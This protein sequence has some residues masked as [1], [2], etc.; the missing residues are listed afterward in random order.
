MKNVDKAFVSGAVLKIEREHSREEIRDM[1]RAMRDSGLNTAVVW[2]AVYW[3]EPEGEH[4]PFETGRQLLFDAE[5]IGIEIIMELAGQ[6]TAMEYAPDFLMKEEYFCVDRR[7]IRDEGSLGYGTLNFNHPEVKALIEAQYTRA[8]EE[9][10]GFRALK[11]YDIWNETQFTSFDEYTLGFFRL[12][13][14]DKYGSIE[15]LN[16]SWDR[17]YK[18]W[19]DVRFTQWMWASVMAY[20]DYQEF[21]KDNIG[22]ILRWMRKAVEKGDTE[23]EILADNIHASVTMDH[24]YERPTDDWTV[25][26]E[27]DQYGIS[28]YPKF[29][30]R[31]TP[32]WLRHQ[33]MVGAHSATPDGRFAI[34]EMQTHHATM[35]NPEGSV[36]PE[37][38]WQWCWEAVSHGANGIIYWKWNPFRK[39]VQTFGRGLVDLKGRKTARLETVKR[40]CGVMEREPALAGCAPQKPQ[41]AILFDR[42]NQ[43][44]TKAYTVGFRGMIGAPDSIYLD[45][46]AGLYRT[47]WEHNVSTVFITPEDL[48]SGK[49]DDIPLVFITT[50]VNMSEKLSSAILRYAENG[51]TVIA[52]GKFGEVSETGLLYYQIPGQG[53]SE[54]LG[55]ALLD[56]EESKSEV[57]LENGGVLRGGHD[58]RRMELFGDGVRALGR[59]DDGEPAV[60]ATALGKGSLVYIS[61]FLWFACKKAPTDDAWSFLSSVAGEK[62][63]PSIIC[64]SVSVHLERLHGENVDYLIAFNYGDECEAAFG[65]SDSV[66]SITDVL[67]GADLGNADEWKAFIP[68]QGVGIFRLSKGD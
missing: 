7:G 22:I 46:L 15:K 5:E 26:G 40:L 4:Y 50:Q 29:L 53:L 43:D 9:Y 41:A 47:L 12:W 48:A 25:A 68:K 32:P 51:G 66:F 28:F 37:E 10:R 24:Y 59:Y 39:G 45:S 54:R 3:W 67:S 1:L 2:P 60:V 30:S 6:I 27:V 61:T 65:I 18:S 16:D 52:D 49:S 20:V 36:S 13:L 58:R 44:F 21:H 56:I 55:F 34:S 42:E 33:T 23:R 19:E 11:G 64:N 35:F 63:V 57:S 8:A 31:Q 17:A 62:L 14:S 38:L